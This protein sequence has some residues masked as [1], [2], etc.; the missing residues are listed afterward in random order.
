[1]SHQAARAQEES[2]T[3]ME[4]RPSF[5]PHQISQTSHL[6]NSSPSTSYPTMSSGNA[7]LSQANPRSRREAQS[8]E[9]SSSKAA[10]SV[11]SQKS[12]T[13][14]SP[15]LSLPSSNPESSD[16]GID[17]TT[18][19]T[20]HILDRPSSLDQLCDYLDVLKDELVSDDPPSSQYVLVQRIPADL[21]LTIVEHPELLKGV[22]ATIRHHEHD[23]LYKMS[24]H[25]HEK[26]GC[27]FDIWISNALGD[28]GLSI[29]NRDFWLGGAG[30]STG[31]VC[32]KQADKSFFPGRN[33]APG[34]PVQWPSLVVEIGISESLPQLRTDAQWW[35]SNSNQKTQ[36][37]VLI[38]ANP[39]TH[40]ADIEIWTQVVNR[41]V[42]ATTR[43]TTRGE[44]TY[45]LERTKSA[46]LR[47]GVVS[48]DVLELDFQ[49]LMGRPTRNPQ[50]TNLQLTPIWIQRLPG[51]LV[52]TVSTDRPANP[53]PYVTPSSSSMERRLQ[54]SR[55]LA[56]Q[57]RN[58]RDANDPWS[59]EFD[60]ETLARIG[61]ILTAD[62][63]VHL[64]K[65]EDLFPAA[66]PIDRSVLNK[67]VKNFLRL[68]SHLPITPAPTSTPTF[69][70]P[71][72]SL[73]R[74]ST[75]T[76]SR[77]SCVRFKPSV[78]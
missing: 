17:P 29:L 22:R 58:Y 25:Y 61:V 39:T 21:F 3:E 30:R 47:N 44:N 8:S 6:S 32:D 38:S 59:N 16:L 76:S 5:A 67:A 27:Y 2:T 54:L 64:P 75:R 42:G 15:A 7:D 49:T 74:S 43:G 14:Q 36:L 70:R 13:P 9:S 77:A 34:T 52:V 53:T 62:S 51:C 57:F 50:E 63:P 10:T 56:L 71:E 37:V 45:V 24:Y 68:T 48:G 19:L 40:D 28:M 12:S 78:Y 11:W 31:R 20:A 69:P 1:M 4:T 73:G 18:L 23:V 60:P 26:I 72:R 35:Y 65:S 46:R 66:W 55:Q 41:R 33:P